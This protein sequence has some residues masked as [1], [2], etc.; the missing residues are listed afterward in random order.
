MLDTTDFIRPALWIGRALWWLGWELM[1]ETVGWSIGWLVWR[2]LT[3][4]RF[5][6]AGF[7]ELDEASG[8][9][10][11]FVELTG[12]AVLAGLI[13]VLSAHVPMG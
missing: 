10:A 11:I 9:V 3:L 5:P 1:V 12:L 8:W 2:G 13:W 4:G 7:K 6:A